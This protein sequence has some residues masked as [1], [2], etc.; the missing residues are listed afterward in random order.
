MVGLL[1]IE[2]TEISGW[3]A[4]VNPQNAAQLLLGFLTAMSITM[5]WHEVHCFQNSGT[6]KFFGPPGTQMWRAVGGPPHGRLKRYGMV[7]GIGILAIPTM[8]LFILY[9]ILLFVIS[10]CM[11]YHAGCV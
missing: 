1:P 8:P 4:S 5:V 3:H 7:F 2:F 9:E 6:S 11:V 10:M